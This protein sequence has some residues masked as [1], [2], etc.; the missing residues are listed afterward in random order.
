LASANVRK[1]GWSPFPMK[2]DL[3]VSADGRAGAAVAAGLVPDAE[4]FFVVFAI[5]IP[6]TRI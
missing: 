4:V 2:I 6:L 3:S 5:A 1:D